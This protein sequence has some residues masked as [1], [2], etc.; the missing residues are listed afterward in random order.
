[1]PVFILMGEPQGPWMTPYKVAIN[2]TIQM[3]ESR[4][5]TYRNLVVVVTLMSLGILVWASIS[6]TVRPLS[7]F[8]LLVPACGL[9]FVLDA[10]A[11]SAWRSRLLDGWSSGEIDFGGFRGA[12]NANVLLPKGTLQS[13]LETLPST[14]D[15]L[16]ERRTSSPTRRMVAAAVTTVHACRSD[17]TSCLTA[18]SA[19][20]ASL[21]VASALLR[22][23]QLL[24]GI[25]AIAALPVVQKWIKQ[26]RMK[27]LRARLMAASRSTEFEKEKY[28]ALIATYDWRPI[29]TSNRDWLA[30]TGIY[31]A[32][33]GSK[34]N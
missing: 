21:L 12:V 32:K 1:M 28:Q 2:D 15:L 29:S 27:N 24:L 11:V 34:M 5:R 3:I 30:D 33:T 25:A 19:I 9:F 8:A 31:A 7:C 18:G 16:A 6:R 4:A 23:P 20:A 14:G 10:R 17:T 22:N 26:W 13:M